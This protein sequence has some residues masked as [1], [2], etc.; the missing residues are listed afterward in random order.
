MKGCNLKMIQN[1]EPNVDDRG[2]NVLINS[3]ILSNDEML[4]AGFRLTQMDTWYLCRYVGDDQE[5]TLNITIS[6]DGS[7]LKID[8]LDEAFCQPY[9]YQMLLGKDSTNQHALNVMNNVETVMQLLS[10]AGIIT[11]WQKGMYI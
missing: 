11:G 4:R 3:K 2:L 9:D 7:R 10:D 8:V 1:G 5:T 6:Q